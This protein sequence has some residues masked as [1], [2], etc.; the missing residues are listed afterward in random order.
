VERYQGA[1][2]SG[3]ANIALVED[4]ELQG[5][6]TPN[7][8]FGCKRVLLSSNYYQTFN[9][10]NVALCTSA[11][12]RI[13]ARGVVTAGGAEHAL[14]TLIIAT[15]FDVTRYLS[16]IAISGRHGHTLA[17]AWQDGAQ[18]YLGI[19]TAGFPNLFQI[20]GPN[21]NK[22]SILFMIECQ[23]AYIVRQLR[24]LDDERLAW[25]DVRAD[26]MHAYNTAIQEDANAIS[27]WAEQCNNYFRH[28]VSGRVVT[29][30]PRNMGQ[31]RADTV[32][33]DDAVYVVQSRDGSQ[34]A[35]S[36][37][38]SAARSAGRML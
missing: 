38:R 1:V 37:T 18:A 28:P 7:Y 27:V 23:T 34:S 32:M 16:T 36:T 9:R 8:A 10:D 15:G 14:D 11:I 20:Y 30:Y 6:L 4:S 17:Q 25:M 35:N 24:R 26:A 5:K 21:T 2:A 22:G 13:T 33:P 3:L 12:R 31:Y 29:Q 19:T